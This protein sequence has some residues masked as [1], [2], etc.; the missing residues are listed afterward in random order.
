MRSGILEKARKDFATVER[1]HASLVTNA[2]R[3]VRASKSKLDAARRRV[4]DLE[5][6][7]VSAEVATN[8]E[9]A[10]ERR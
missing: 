7:A 2:A 10:Q 4:M 9:R 6:A 1:D 5:F 3:S 8:K